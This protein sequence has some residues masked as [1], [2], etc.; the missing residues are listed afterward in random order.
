MNSS[1]D[2]ILRVHDLTVD[3]PSKTQTVNVLKGIDLS[4]KRGEIL[5]LVG[6]SG[7]GKS[8]FARCL[9]RLESPAVIRRGTLLLD[10]M[11]LTDRT[12]KQ[13]QA[14]RG[15]K[16]TMAFQNPESALD[17]V[18]TMGYQLREV[19]PRRGGGRRRQRS[20]VDTQIEELLGRVGIASPRQRCRQY[21]HEWSRGMLQRGQLAMAFLT[22]P[23]VLILDEITSALD[24]TVCLQVLD[25]V[26]R[27]RKKHGTAI[28]L[29][30]H[31]LRLASQICD[32]VAVM[33]AGRIVETGEVGDIFQRPVHPYTRLLVAGIYSTYSING[34]GN[35]G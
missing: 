19:L 18:F 26:R 22:G 12:P 14:I 33:Q 30:T 17:P 23:E 1:A 3:F 2:V 20:A 4:L 31:D 8:L 5:G 24:P 15:R 29:I 7:C 10:G 21:P 9:L 11:S 32:R 13:M 34:A 25:V 28:I 27:L 35:K 6:E 16:I